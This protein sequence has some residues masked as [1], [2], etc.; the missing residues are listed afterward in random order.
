MWLN[1]GQY[2]YYLKYDNKNYSVPKC[3]NIDE[4]DLKTGKKIID[5]KKGLVKM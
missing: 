4:L 1:I 2:G 3:F 5:Y